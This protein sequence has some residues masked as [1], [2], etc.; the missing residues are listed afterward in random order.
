MNNNDYEK[1]VQQ[2]YASLGISQPAKMAAGGVVEDTGGMLNAA[3][4]NVKPK[5]KAEDEAY[6]NAHNQ[7]ATDH[8]AYSDAYNKWVADW[9]AGKTEAAYAGIAEPT[10]PTLPTAQGDLDINAYQAQLAAAAQNKAASRVGGIRAFAN[11]EAYNLAGHAGV[12]SFEDGGEAVAVQDPRSMDLEQFLLENSRTKFGPVDVQEV[13]SS[14]GQGKYDTRVSKDVDGFQAFADVDVGGKKL[15]QVGAS[16]VG[17][18]RIGNYEVQYVYDP[19]TKQPVITGAIRKE[20]SPTSDVSAEGVYVPQR[21]GKDYYNAG[22]KYTKRF[23]N[24]GEAQADRKVVSQEES[25]YRSGLSPE[26]YAKAIASY[27]L[28][29]AELDAIL[30][31][32]KAQKYAKEVLDTVRPGK[33]GIYGEKADVETMHADMYGNP[34]GRYFDTGKGV[35]NKINAVPKLPAAGVYTN[36]TPDEVTVNVNSG[37]PSK[38]VFVH[39]LQHKLDDDQGSNR[40]N[41]LKA[42]KFPEAYVRDLGN[43]KR[44]TDT[45][46]DYSTLYDNVKNAYSTYRKKYKLSG[47]FSERGLIPELKRIESTLPVGMNIFDTDIGKAVS[48]GLPKFKFAYYNQTAPSKGTY[49]YSVDTAEQAGALRK[50]IE[51][52]SEKDIFA[53]P[54]RTVRALKEKVT[55]FIKSKK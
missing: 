8:A 31:P 6:F 22:I 24:G 15:S 27:D 10:A 19:E 37:L 33:D 23:E 34:S 12:S 9:N 44:W 43:N 54:K 49:M 26:Q 51:P 18:G 41:R 2:S 52:G 47:D 28:P 21:D 39:E 17:H 25:G 3:A 38:N 7:Y 35:L 53:E 5:L 1:R 20:L 55:D 29:Q 16:Y 30:S 11:P 14:R 45:S 13:R 40:N 32:T 4:R 42:E 46:D 36:A 50:A 48:K